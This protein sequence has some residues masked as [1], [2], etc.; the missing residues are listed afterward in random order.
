MMEPLEALLPVLAMM[1]V[2]QNSPEEGV[3]QAVASQE[4][5]QV[6]ESHPYI[7]EDLTLEA[8]LNGPDQRYWQQALMNEMENLKQRGTYSERR[9]TAIGLAVQLLRTKWV[10]KRKRNTDGE[11]VSFKA[12]IVA[13][14]GHAAKR[15]RL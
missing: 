8:A 11:V 5:D 7:D 14:G 2:E 6:F 1:M 9:T 3:L 15:D 13:R 10:F 12:R 4:G